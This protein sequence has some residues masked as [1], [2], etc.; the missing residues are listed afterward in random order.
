MLRGCQVA[1][2]NGLEGDVPR[3][4]IVGQGPVEALGQFDLFV[5]EL[6]AHDTRPQ[7]VNFAVETGLEGLHGVVTVNA[8]GVGHLHG[9][10]AQPVELVHQLRQICQRYDGVVIHVFHGLIGRAHAH[11]AGGPHQHDHDSEKTHQTDQPGLDGEMAR[12]LAQGVEAECD[13]VAPGWRGGA[14]ASVAPGAFLRRGGLITRVCPSHYSF[15][16][17]LWQ[18]KRFW[19]AEHT[20]PALYVNCWSLEMPRDWPNLV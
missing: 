9:V 13:S 17:G 6:F 10:D 1:A 20:L 19:K 11:E 5:A 16:P 3:T 12:A 18:K 2:Q 7:F 14:L 8:A 15:D 4:A